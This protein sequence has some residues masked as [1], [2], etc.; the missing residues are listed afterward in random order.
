MGTWNINKVNKWI[1]SWLSCILQRM[2]LNSVASSF[3]DVL[4]GV[5]QGS[6]LGQFLL[7]IYIN[8]IDEGLANRILKLQMIQSW[9][10]LLIMEMMPKR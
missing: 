2:V 6:V 9:L 7:I 3:V 1:E 5:P 4:S 10:V 8:D